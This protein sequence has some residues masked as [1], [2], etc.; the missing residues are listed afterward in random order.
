[1]MLDIIAQNNWERPIYFSGGAFGNDDYIWMKDYLQLDG[2]AYKLVPIKTPVSENNPYNMGRIDSDLMYELVKKWEWGNSG[3]PKMY[4]DV[5]TRKNSI[6]YRGNM[7]RLIEVL[8][9]EGK[10]KKAEEIAD[11]AQEKMPVDLF[12]YY[13]FLE[14]FVGAYYEIG[15]KNKGRSL[16]K[17]ISVK[18]QENLTYY[19]RIS[20]SNKSKYVQT[21][22][23]DIE[24]YK[25]LVDTVSYYESEEFITAEMDRFN[26][27]LKLFTEKDSD[28]L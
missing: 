27:F 15:Q 3:D 22:Y 19:S 5:E 1:M 20:E 13:T 23:S 4:H 7:A 24:R 26:G 10:Y 6:T 18:Y 9:N 2:F 17:K 8:I 25:S 12:G 11:L 14:P 28:N 21:I 16:F